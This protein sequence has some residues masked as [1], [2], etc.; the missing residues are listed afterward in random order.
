[1]E[2]DYIYCTSCGYEAFDVYVAFVGTTA[3]GSWYECPACKKE[4]SI[5]ETGCEE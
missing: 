2:V 3:S 4:T 1:M 5:V